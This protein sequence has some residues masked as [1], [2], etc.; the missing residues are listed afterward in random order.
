M[1]QNG[2]TT[3]EDGL[4][5]SYKTKQYTIQ[6]CAHWCLPKGFENFVQKTCTE[7][8]LTLLI[9]AQTCKQPKYSSVDE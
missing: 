9:V 6:Q 3:F 4:V 8:F 2:T 7:I 1:M 5:A